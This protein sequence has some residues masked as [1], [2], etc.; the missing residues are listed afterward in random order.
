[1]QLGK[2]TPEYADHL[3]CTILNPKPSQLLHLARRENTKGKDEIVIVV[4]K[5]ELLT[6]GKLPKAT[7]DEVDKYLRSVK[8]KNRKI[9]KAINSKTDQE[10]IEVTN[11][12]KKKKKL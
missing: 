2:Y 10:E 3:D 8:H 6:G 5:T 12:S 1:M 7:L 9:V 4:P 11:L